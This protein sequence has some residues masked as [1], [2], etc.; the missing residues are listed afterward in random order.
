M[1]AFP[2][3]L[4]Q[5]DSGNENTENENLETEVVPL[6]EGI[7]AEKAEASA[8]Q[9]IVDRFGDGLHTAYERYGDETVRN[10][11]VFDFAAGF[12]TAVLC[13]FAFRGLQTFLKKKGLSVKLADGTRERIDARAINDL[14]RVATRDLGLPRPPKLKISQDGQ[15]I[16]V[17]ARAEIY[18]FQKGPV[19][20]D[21]LE[22]SL[23]RQFLDKHNLDI[24]KVH[25]TVTRVR[26]HNGDGILDTTPEVEN[27][28][29]TAAE[30]AKSAPAQST[31]AMATPAATRPQE[32]PAEAVAQMQ[33][34]LRSESQA[35][36]TPSVTTPPASAAAVADPE[37][38]DAKIANVPAYTP[39]DDEGVEH[40]ES[41]IALEQAHEPPLEAATADP[42]L[43]QPIKKPAPPQNSDLE[44][45]S[46][47][48]FGDIGLPEE[49]SEKL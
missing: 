36:G 20:K 13:Y 18:E 8:Q 23:R 10:E 39:S 49:E 40:P 1:A 25:L 46:V 11:F 43:Q 12:A 30:T 41:A 44:P 27:Q 16:R 29:I 33:E 9:R 45:E 42:D 6:E 31:V 17:E 7:T 34:E 37:V 3:V 24:K 38:T 26:D 21:Q 19:I 48:D 4:A 47:D 15:G 22:V 14:Q 28:A 2:L 32:A 5:A 35:S